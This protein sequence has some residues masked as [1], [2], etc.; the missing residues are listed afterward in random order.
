MWG[1]VREFDGDRTMKLCAG[2]ASRARRDSCIRGDAR[3]VGRWDDSERELR[4]AH[5]GRRRAPRCSSRAREPRDRRHGRTLITSN[6]RFSYGA[7]PAT[8]LIIS[9][10]TL[11]RLLRVCAA[12]VKGAREGGG[13]ERCARSGVAHGA[14]ESA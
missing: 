2:A 8:S 1:D 7:R 6:T 11:T 14:R 12:E 5:E 10:M 3:I 9:R 4:V 13:R